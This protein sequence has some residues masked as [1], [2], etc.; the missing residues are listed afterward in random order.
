MK[1]LVMGCNGQLGHSLADTASVNVN[2]IGLD[3]PELDITDASAVL[4]ICR[5]TRPD[6]IVNATAYTA[7]DQAESESALATSVNVEGPRNIAIASR[8]VGARLIH[9]STDFVFDGQSSTPY[10]AD[11]VTNPLSV[12]GQ[13]KR[14][15]ELAVLEETSGTAVV[16]RTS[17]L[18]SKTGSNFVKTMLRLMGERDELGIVADQFGS[19]TWADS[20]AEALWAF[21]DAP[22][23]SGIFHWTDSGETSWQEFA[24]A[25]QQEALALGL[26]G[27]AIPI[28]AI[29]TED[30]PTAATRPAYSVLDCSSTIQAINIQPAEWRTN[31]RRMLKGMTE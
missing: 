29:K 7:V 15:G 24:V 3:L 28:H 23:H 2:L 8:E 30:Y 27:K 20:L 17:W 9:I 11:A 21:V 6:V 26:L 13:T 19:P 16:I 1:T 25:I 31:L 22:E 12:Y 4:E 10:K 18:Y 14:D 5:E